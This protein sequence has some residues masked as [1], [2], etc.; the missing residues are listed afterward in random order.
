MQPIVVFITCSN[1]FEGQRITKILIENK[2][3][4]CVNLVK[5][6]KSVYWWKGNIETSNEVLLIV[7]S[8]AKILNKLIEV[9]KSNHSY[10]V[11]EIIAI[12]IIGGNQD[13][14]KW[15]SESISQSPL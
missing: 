14:L 4:A 2:L 11:P 1:L 12:P 15:I 13:Y 8:D 10:T 5:D 9:V 3:A 6:I 7:K